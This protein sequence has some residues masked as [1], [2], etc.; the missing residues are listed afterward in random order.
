MKHMFLK[1]LA[2]LLVT[3]QHVILRYKNR[4]VFDGTALELSDDEYRQIQ[5][6]EILSIRILNDTLILETTNGNK[7]NFYLDDIDK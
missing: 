4:V 3:G 1:K 5:T 6:L 2:E 7:K